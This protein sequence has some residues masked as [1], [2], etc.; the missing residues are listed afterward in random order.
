VNRTAT[1][2][3]ISDHPDWLPGE[4]TEVLLENG[5]WYFLYG[6]DNCYKNEVPAEPPWRKAD[7]TVKELLGE[8]RAAWRAYR[9]LADLRKLDSGERLE[10]QVIDLLGRQQDFGICD[11]L[12]NCAIIRHELEAKSTA[13]GGAIG[14][15]SCNIMNLWTT[16][17]DEAQ[18]RCLEIRAEQQVSE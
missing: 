1:Q 15:A 14:G 17:R 12:Y 7:V 5:K 11:I 3:V 13:L 9:E 8:N 18:R 10:K 2:Q 6:K 4:C 16:V